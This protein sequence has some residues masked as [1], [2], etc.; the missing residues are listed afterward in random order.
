ML[1]APNWDLS[2]LEGKGLL[3]FGWGD[4]GGMGEPVLV[5]GRGGGV[6][7]PFNKED[8]E[9]AKL[10]KVEEAADDE[11]VDDEEETLGGIDPSFLRAVNGSTGL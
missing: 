3:L 6:A 9:V 11:D 2:S 10:H 4:E 5:F 8:A 7:D 1:V